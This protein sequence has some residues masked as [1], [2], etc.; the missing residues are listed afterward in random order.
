MHE[1]VHGFAQ[2]LTK[3]ECLVVEAGEE[4]ELRKDIDSHRKVRYL[5]LLPRPDSQFS[6]SF[7]EAKYVRDLH[8]LKKWHQIGTIL[9]QLLG[10]FTSLR[11][12]NLGESG[13][14]ELPR[15][16]GNLIHLRLLNLKKNN[17]KRLP[18]TV[19]NL[20]YLQT[21][22]L[23]FC[24]MLE[25]LPNGMGKLINLR[26]LQFELVH[27]SKIFPK[28]IGGLSSLRTLTEF[29]VI[30]DDGACNLCDLGDLNNLQGH[31]SIR[32]RAEVAA[33]VKG[34]E[35]AKLKNKIHLKGLTL[36]F[37]GMKEE[38]AAGVIEALQPHLKL[39]SLEIQDYRGRVFP[40]WL[41]R[42]SKLR[43]LVIFR[44]PNFGH[45]PKLGNL[46]FL[47]TLAMYYM[48]CL[49]KLGQE[50]FIGEGITIPLPSA[51]AS[52][53]SLSG[54][55]IIRVSFP[56]LKRF[57]LSEMEE[58]EEWEMMITDENEDDGI[59]RRIMPFLQALTILNCPKLTA[60]PN[61]LLRQ[62]PLEELHI[63]GCT[64]LRQRY[65]SQDGEDWHLVS[66]VPIISVD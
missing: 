4:K 35:K 7:C 38:G 33:D 63:E 55:A 53:S 54:T 43:H 36:D 44:C 12:L 13:I 18:E 25:E 47:E 39:E 50:D 9:P 23:E 17:I 31:L 6:F 10:K 1:F 41:E 19:Q 57:S 16:V 61:H 20:H 62:A 37:E 59:V 28:G 2:Y 60:L 14:Q 64:L 45:L 30:N 49:K 58:W 11:A 15:E 26:Y 29:L 56:K 3:N 65:S 52:S 21:L 24:D 46:P 40:S 34:A 48:P 42:L 66:H 22:D 27:C 8:V 51:L 5:S 32:W